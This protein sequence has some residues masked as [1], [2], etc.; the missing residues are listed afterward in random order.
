MARKKAKHD[1]RHWHEEDQFWEAVRPVLFS[2]S[3]LEKASTEVPQ[4]IE[5]LEMEPGMSVLDSCCGVGRHTLE[6][7][8]RGFRVTGLDRTRSYLD[9]AARTLRDAD[10]GAELCQG[11]IRSFHRAR[12]F[13]VVLNL[14]TS[15]GYF[16][17]P[18]DD[19][20]VLANFYSSLKPGGQLL[21]EMAGKELVARDLQ[22]RIW[23]REED[24]FL[25]EEP[26]V[27]PGWNWIDNRWIVVTNRK[28]VELE[29]HLR[30]Y[31]ACEL[32]GLI[33][34]A[35]FE[36]IEVFGDLEGSYYDDQAHRLVVTAR[37]PE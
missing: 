11:D 7:A 16:E 27:R 24:A 2:R 8:R 31:S 17:H 26:R 22:E 5:L 19:D 13:D 36:E 23:H 4:I 33:A 30:L 1:R 21:I 14:F 37:K 18:G 10:L 3:R 32:T 9:E 15:F 28:R 34:C 35:G 25:L 20:R 29:L 6:L 12:S